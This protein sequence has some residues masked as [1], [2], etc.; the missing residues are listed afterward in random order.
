MN[1]VN[2]ILRLRTNV[3]YVPPIILRYN[4]FEMLPYTPLNKFFQ[5]SYYE[6]RQGYE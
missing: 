5:S 1:Y 6:A 4:R 3:Q 2:T